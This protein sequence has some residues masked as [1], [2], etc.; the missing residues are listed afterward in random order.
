MWHKTSHNVLCARRRS[1]KAG[2][3]I[4]PEPEDLRTRGLMVWALVR[5]P[6]K[7]QYQ[8]ARPDISTWAKR[9]NLPFLHHFLLVNPLMDWMPSYPGETTGCSQ[10]WNTSI[11]TPG[12]NTLPLVQACL[13]IKLTITDNNNHIWLRGRKPMVITALE[14]HSGARMSASL[15]HA[16]WSLLVFLSVLLGCS[17]VMRILWDAELSS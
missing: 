12:N 14:H 1:R 11:G 9:M 5:M 4:H 13:H 10:F 6:G 17:L 3:I 2:G 8:C 7:Q 16:V 15:S